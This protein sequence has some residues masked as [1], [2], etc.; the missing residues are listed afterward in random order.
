MKQKYNYSLFLILVLFLGRA[1]SLKVEHRINKDNSVEFF[2]EKTEFNTHTIILNFGYLNNTSASDKVIKRVSNK[3]GKLLKIRPIDSQ[4]QIG[5]NYSVRYYNYAVNPKIDNDFIYILPFEKGQKMQVEPLVNLGVI[6]SNR[7]FMAKNFKAVSF[8]SSNAVDIYPARKGVVIE[9]TNSYTPD[10]SK[11][12]VYHNKM[13]YITIEH[14]DGSLARYSG[15]DKNSMKVSLG[16]SVYPTLTNMGTTAIYDKSMLHRINFYVCYVN[17]KDGIKL[18]DLNNYKLLEMVFIDP[19]FFHKNNN[20]A[21]D[22]NALYES[23]FNEATLFQNFNKRQIR[24][25]K[26]G[27]LIN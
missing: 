4:Q 21:L 11:N 24:N 22:F 6:S 8:T 15:F 3:T 5:F 13:N 10:L 20:A 23:D 1:Q 19:V 17:T 27:K 12:F 7:Q 2:Y 25:Y 18:M 14:N 9:I 26:K 16:Q